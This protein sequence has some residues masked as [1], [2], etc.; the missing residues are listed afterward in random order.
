MTSSPT[1]SY[2]VVFLS[3]GLV[4]SIVA[5][6]LAVS[7]KRVLQIDRNDQYGSSWSTVVR[8]DRDGEEGGRGDEG[9]DSAGWWGSSEAN[10]PSV[11]TTAEAGWWGSSEANVPSVTTTAEAGGWGSSEANVPSTTTTAE[12]KAASATLGFPN[13]NRSGANISSAG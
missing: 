9:I 2:D 3:T 4:E 1:T 12:A 11:T 5:A 13:A 7:G 10:V 8:G 6:A